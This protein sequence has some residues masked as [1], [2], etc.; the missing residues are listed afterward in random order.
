MLDFPFFATVILV[1]VIK[2][3]TNDLGIIAVVTPNRNNFGVREYINA[4]DSDHIII[5][6][7]DNIAFPNGPVTIS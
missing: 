6:V 3:C 2:L 7:L 5:E 1:A 4:S